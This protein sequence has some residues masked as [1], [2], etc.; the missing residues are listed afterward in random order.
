MADDATSASLS[1]DTI[2][3]SWLRLV[4]SGNL[5]PINMAAK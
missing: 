3:L 5:Q 2:F 4:A 1:I